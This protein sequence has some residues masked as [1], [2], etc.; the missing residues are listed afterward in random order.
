M[1]AWAFSLLL[2]CA[3]LEGSVLRSRRAS[4]NA[5]L[6]HFSFDLAVSL[7]VDGAHDLTRV[8]PKYSLDVDGYHSAVVTLEPLA[9]WVSRVGYVV[10][11]SGGRIGC[12]GF[13]VG[14]KVTSCGMYPERHKQGGGY[15]LFIFRGEG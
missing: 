9:L 3:G 1:V 11:S 7:G 13:L 12:D 5:P 4:L 14:E 10:S 15:V 8:V 6:L 2:R